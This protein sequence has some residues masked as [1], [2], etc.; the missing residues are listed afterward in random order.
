MIDTTI[1]LGN[2]L[3]IAVI[4]GGGIIFMIRFVSKFT[5]LDDAHKGFSMRFDKID[6][7][8]RKITAVSVQLA[9]QDER[10]NFVDQRIIMLAARLDGHVARGNSKDSP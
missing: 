9:R 4:A 5:L 7:E 2:L 8:L 3:Q 10:L 1:S 6:E